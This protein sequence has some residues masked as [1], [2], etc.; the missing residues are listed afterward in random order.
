[1]KKLLLFFCF[2]FLFIYGKSQITATSNLSR[3]CGPLCVQ[4]RALNTNSHDTIKTWEWFFGNGDTSSTQNASYCYPAAGTYKAYVIGRGSFGSI[5]SDTVTITVYP[6]P[7]AI[8]TGNSHVCKG[9][10]DTLYASGGGNYY[11]SNGS[12]DSIYYT[13]AINADSAINVTVISSHGC[14]D[15]ASYAITDTCPTGINE[16]YNYAQ[17]QVYPN[18]TNGRFIIS[19]TGLP[20]KTEMEIYNMIGE[21]VF[22]SQLTRNITQVN[23]QQPPGLYLC[24]I[25]N[26]YGQLLLSTKVIIQ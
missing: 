25:I 11:W 23:L 13:G 8:I 3:G 15:T 12:T 2:V 10:K 22:E 24:R 7:T 26:S 1:M 21:K 4:F 6:T 14:I 19:S 16:I 20:Q 5:T 9:T 18:P 17:L